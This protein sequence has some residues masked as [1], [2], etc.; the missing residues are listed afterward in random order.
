LGYARRSGSK[1][2]IAYLELA[3]E[4]GGVAAEMTLMDAARNGLLERVKELLLT[5]AADQTDPD[6]ATALMR[7]V[8]QGH[9]EI[10]DSLCSAGADVHRTDTAGR[11]LWDYALAFGAKPEILRCLI[12]HGLDPNRPD[13]S[14]MSP[15]IR[16]VMVSGG[17]EA[18][19]VVRA[20][21]EGGA[22]VHATYTPQVPPHLAE[23][24]ARLKA[25]GSKLADRIGRTVTAVDL[26]KQQGNR[27]AYEVLKGYT[28]AASD[29]YDAAM[30]ELKQLAKKADAAFEAE[31]KRLGNLLRAKP[32]P[33]KKRKGVVHYFA[34]LTEADTPATNAADAADRGI[35]E[36]AFL[37]RLQ[38]ETRDK[39]Y[40]LVYAEKDWE[41]K[42]L[43]RLLLFPTAQ[44]VVALAASGTNGDNYGTGTREV[45]NWCAETA[46]N[47][48]LHV[49]GASFDS[50]EL[51]FSRPVSQP[52][53]LAKRIAIFCPDT[54]VNPDDHVAVAAFARELAA[55]GSCFFWWD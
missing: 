49:S 37:R 19:E 43:T 45:V 33:W 6:G 36:T 20:L 52:E 2:T 32:Q 55:Q 47:N 34:R 21:V 48:P 15:L 7:A 44:D 41:G 23:H 40:T 31:A 29:A 4:R 27:K 14:G 16:S 42:G 30:D 17:Q 1:R 28:G 35:R 3:F 18:D 38:S 12:R 46:K 51:D 9:A 54:E 22:D 25:V 53:A 39:G 13:F 50:M 11:N 10:A 8:Q 26:A 24:A 5:E